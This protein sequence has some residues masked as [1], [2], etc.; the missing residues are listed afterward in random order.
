MELIIKIPDELYK[1]FKTPRT[2][3]LTEAFDQRATLIRA[4]QNG[5]PLPKGHGRLIDAD[6]L[7]LPSEEMVS[8]LIINYA[9]TIVE[10][11]ESESEK[12]VKKNDI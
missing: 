5:T 9:K 12:E 6:E 2:V 4:I 3:G 11:D 8:R 10:A 7:E 1:K